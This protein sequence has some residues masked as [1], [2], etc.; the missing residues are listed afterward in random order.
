MSELI[1]ET[2]T[3]KYAQ[4]VREIMQMFVHQ[5]YTGRVL[6]FLFLLSY[7]CESLAVECENFQDELEKI[8]EMDAIVLLRGMAWSNDKLVRALNEVTRAREKMT[9]WLMVGCDLRHS[10]MEREKQRVVEEFDKRRDRL[11]NATPR[12]SS[13]SNRGADCERASAL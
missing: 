7:L 2:A 10:D 3:W 4:Q 12:F 8:M 1:D 9:T 11:R 5:H 13:A 6:V